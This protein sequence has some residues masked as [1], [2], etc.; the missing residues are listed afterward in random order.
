VS[1]LGLAPV[2]ISVTSSSGIGTNAKNLRGR[3]RDIRDRKSDTGRPRRSARIP[4]SGRA[5]TIQAARRIDD[6]L[7]IILIRVLSIIVTTLKVPGE[8]VSTVDC[9][10][11]V[12]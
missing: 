8:P 11:S 2:A 5:A 9:G 10:L 12:T 6:G 3:S 4:R 7:S 1:Q